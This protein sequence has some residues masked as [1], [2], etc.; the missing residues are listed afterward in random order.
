MNGGFLAALTPLGNFISEHC[1][2]FN[3]AIKPS[4]KIGGIL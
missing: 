2:I 3:F 4:K 1:K